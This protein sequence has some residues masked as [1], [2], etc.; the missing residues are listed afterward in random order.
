MDTYGKM[1][2]KKHD[3]FI[4]KKYKPSEQR[5]YEIINEA[6]KAGYK[7]LIVNSEIMLQIIESVLLKKG[8]LMN[9]E[10]SESTDEDLSD[11]V[12]K[13]VREIRENPLL[14]IRLKEQL[15]W[16]NDTSC[17]DINSITLYCDGNKFTLMSNG[18]LYGRSEINNFFSKIIKPVLI[19]Y[20]YE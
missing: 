10:M 15:E 1:F 12:E 4:I 2:R 13:L 14:F 11:N 6:R 9:V 20:F 3:E 16:T 8:I 5:Y 7:Q 19:S 17:I 18:V